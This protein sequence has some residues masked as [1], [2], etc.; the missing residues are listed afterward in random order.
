MDL[1]PIRILEIEI[2]QPLFSV[3]PEHKGQ[4]YQHALCL[5]RLHSQPLG[6]IELDLVHGPV[7]ADACA[8]HI[9]NTLHAQINM[10]LQQDTLPIVTTLDAEGLPSPDTISCI[11]AR[12]DF[13]AT[14]PFV[15]I[16]VPTH[17]RPERI[18]ACLD[19]LLALHY[20]HYEIIIVDNAPDTDATANFIH[21]TYQDRPQI[22]Y[23]REDRPGV[24]W[25]RNKGVQAAKGEIL[26]FADDDV[27]VDRYWLV[28]LVKAFHIIPAIGCV[29]G[30]ILSA[31]LETPA[32]IL[33][34]QHDAESGY[35][36][37]WRFTRHIFSKQKR[38]VHLYK[39]ALFGAGASMAFR[40]D[41]L[42]SIGG[43]DPALGTQGLVQSGEDIAAFFKVLMHGYHVVYEPAALVYH[44][45]RREYAALCQQIY[46]YGV[47]ATAYLTKNLL[48]Y[49]QLLLDLCIKVPYALLHDLLTNRSDH[50]QKSKQHATA[51]LKE[52]ATMA[53][54][55]M[56]RG[57]FAYLKSRWVTRGQ[58]QALTAPE[59]DA[60]SYVKKG[61]LVS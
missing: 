56:L 26:A 27:I 23:V 22:R 9:W 28:E 57:P 6:T 37:S 34:E 21:E 53:R 36:D 24:S 45:N 50:T 51:Y 7:S 47:G 25:A 46:H 8:Q 3:T 59:V 31:E 2:G 18:P 29:T 4:V 20:P 30:L 55:G 52:L 5:V 1:T 12:E 39:V 44:K 32:Q 14:A 17:E 49:P 13:L 48:D 16:I 10:H 38:H 19:A 33:F 40:A 15:S 43:F 58:R 54:K 42:R 61:K 41:L 35:N 11:Q 60:T